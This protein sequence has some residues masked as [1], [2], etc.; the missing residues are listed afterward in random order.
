M[1]RCSSK[2]TYSGRATAYVAEHPLALAILQGL[3]TLRRLR[4]AR[5]STKVLRAAK[6]PLSISP[7]TRAKAENRSSF[8]ST[9]NIQLMFCALLK[10]SRVQGPRGAEEAYR[11]DL[12]SATNVI[13]SS[14]SHLSPVKER[15]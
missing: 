13:S 8:Q 10:A 9:I 2:G 14:C 3:S 1:R 11:A 5:G 12:C 4:L 6:R 7:T 15:S